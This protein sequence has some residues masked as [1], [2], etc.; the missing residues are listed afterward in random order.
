MRIGIFLH[1]LTWGGA[2][3]R[4]LSLAR[5]FQERG[6][7][8]SLIV[9]ERGEFLKKSEVSGLEIKELQ[10]GV[11]FRLFLKNASKKRKMAWS[12]FAFARFLRSSRLDVL[13]SGGNHAHITA[14]SALVLS[15]RRIPLVL[16]LSSHVTASLRK[17][18]KLSKK[19]RFFLARKLYPFSDMVIAVSRAVAEDLKSCISIPES[20]IR[21][22]YNPIYCPELLDKVR[23]KPSHPWLLDERG[24]KVPVL[25]AAGRLN[26]QKGIDVLL[27]AFALAVSR[28]D[29]RLIILGEGKKRASFE[30]LIRNL[31][32]EGKVDMPGYVQNPLAY[33]AR[34][35]LFC[36]ASIFEGMPGVVIEALAAG[37]PVVCTDSSGG[38]AEILGDE[39]YGVLVPVGDEKA[40]A[41]GMI[42]GLD[43][44]WDSAELKKRAA[45]FSVDKAA[46]EYLA[47]LEAL[48]GKMFSRKS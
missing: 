33:M 1:G 29:M 48:A 10:K 30:T 12:K 27:R 13:V 47:A 17:K 34:A 24:R 46:E 42:D 9:V 4:L 45:F 18:K 15:G 25:L 39:K 5:A 41:S 19:I 22:I 32:L 35:D 11:L 23:E 26:L 37:C 16:R 31:K 8:V 3:R 7:R 43:R 20:K 38:A 6:H 2:T 21:V 14:I 44:T 40:L 36:H 28:R